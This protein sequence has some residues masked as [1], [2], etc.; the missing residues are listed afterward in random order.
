[1]SRF[2]IIRGVS[3]G[4]A[5]CELSYRDRQPIDLEKAR[6]QHAAYEAVLESLDCRVVRLDAEDDLPDSVFVEDTAVVLDEVAV[7]TRPG[8]A[9]RR[10]ET[11]SIA[12][13]LGRYRELLRIMAPATLDGGDVLRIGRRL[14]VGRTG[15][16]NEAGVAQ[17]GELVSGY[18]YE[19]R[20]VA[21][22]GCLHLK[23]AVST[24]S[25]STILLD[26]AHV[27]P[28]EFSDYDCTEI[29][30]GESAAGNAL[31]IGETLL[32]PAGCPETRDRLG[33]MGIDVIEVDNT[34]LAKAEGGLTCCSLI[35]ETGGSGHGP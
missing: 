35:V 4:I 8:A 10:P 2:A 11:D 30:D 21:V 27:D 22:N 7:I 14:Y 26:P 5:S 9:S 1:V 23:S 17:L 20:E 15:R 34:E 13:A 18:G 16:S 12:D 6:A 31:L 29:R 25:G 28:C 3:P 33:A 24:V 19:V 32:L